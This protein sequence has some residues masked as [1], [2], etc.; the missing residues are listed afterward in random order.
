MI[1]KSRKWVGT[2]KYIAALFNT[3]FLVIRNY[4]TRNHDSENATCLVLKPK[5]H[6]WFC[7]LRT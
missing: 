3:E 6:V 7:V 1:N 5:E 4:P 2:S